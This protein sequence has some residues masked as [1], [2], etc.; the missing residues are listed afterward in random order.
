[1]PLILVPVA[2]LIIMVIL[3]PSLLILVAIAL[4][5]PLFTGRRK[6]E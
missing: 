2:V 3:Y 4:T 5:V 6:N 1:M